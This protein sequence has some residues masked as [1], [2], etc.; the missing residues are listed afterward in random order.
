LLLGTAHVHAS[1]ELYA[2]VSAR[3]ALMQDVAAYKWH[4]QLPIEDLER[5]ALV[6]KNSVNQ[7]LRT[8]LRPAAAEAFF[9]AQ[10][11]AAKA[12]QGYWFDRWA[13]DLAPPAGLVPDLA[14]V[15]RPAL[16]ALGERIIAAVPMEP[17]C[18]SWQA[19]ADAIAVKGLDVTH[20]AEL[21]AAISEL[22]FFPHRL[23]QIRA[24]GRLRIGT[25][26]DYA[27]FSHRNDAHEAFAGID[28][29]LA[30]D[31]AA[32]LEVAP[33]FV[34]TSWPT[35]MADLDSGAFDIAMSGVSLTQ[36][37][38]RS[39]YFSPA[40]YTGGKTPV[41]RCAD[42][43]RFASL[44]AIDRRE[45]RVI[46]NPGGTNERFVAQHIH[47]AEVRRYPDNRSIFIEIIQGRA[48]VM[49]TDRIEVQLQTARHPEL[50][51][52]M[53]VNLNR[54][55]KAYL[56]PKDA[57]WKEFVDTWLNNRLGDGTVARVFSAN[58][59]TVDR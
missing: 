44:A 33:V 27:P 19:F 14:A 41:A 25:T 56:M 42:A 40:Y 32:A 31:L 6:I 30:E 47:L 2:L 38:Q 46:V 7:A 24:T 11:Q 20:K 50:C 21:Y 43:A 29:T 17:Q 15:T 18:R 58:G 39:G 10:I 16:L 53:A 13:G 5:E 54:Q 51:S 9:R 52:T 45:V 49:I 12:V 28:I 55:Q 34:P 23:A 22:S 8:G 3:L 59:V 37:R 48:D 57:V 1:C 35:L 36:E 4:N 26:G